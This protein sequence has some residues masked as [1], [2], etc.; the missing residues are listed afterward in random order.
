MI[1]TPSRSVYKFIKSENNNSVME[2]T[3][4]KN[5]TRFRAKVDITYSVYDHADM[6][7]ASLFIS[8]TCLVI[9]FGQGGYY[10]C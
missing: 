7:C 6:A 5:Y 10:I 1:F 9:K 8:F 4:K 3:G 2:G